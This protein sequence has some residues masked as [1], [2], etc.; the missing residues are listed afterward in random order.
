ML[1]FLSRS[2]LNSYRRAARARLPVVSRVVWAR[3]DADEEGHI[4]KE[5]FAKAIQGVGLH[6]SKRY[7]KILYDHCDA[8]RSG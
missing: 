2:V 1:I 8:D 5:Q 7:A 6:V 4:D 3:R